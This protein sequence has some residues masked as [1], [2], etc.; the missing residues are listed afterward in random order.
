MA[1]W[2][3]KQ[4]PVYATSAPDEDPLPSPVCRKVRRAEQ[5]LGLHRFL[6]YAS[7]EKVRGQRDLRQGSQASMMRSFSQLERAPVTRVTPATENSCLGLAG[8]LVG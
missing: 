1:D 7:A 2:R 3:R 8:Q 6:T 4:R 5:G